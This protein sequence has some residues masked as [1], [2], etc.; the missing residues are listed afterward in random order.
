MNRIVKECNQK[1]RERTERKGNERKERKE[2]KGEEII[3][4]SN[5]LYRLFQFSLFPVP[6]VYF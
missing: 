1:G 5:K 2:R 3:I 6:L 4:S